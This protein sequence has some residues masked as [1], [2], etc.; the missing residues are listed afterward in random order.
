MEQQNAQKGLNN[1]EKNRAAPNRSKF[2][3]KAF[4]VNKIKETRK[5]STGNCSVLNY[6]LR[7]IVTI[8]HDKSLL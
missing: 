8:G 7:L 2:R 3:L 4:L 5:S 6:A 1:Y